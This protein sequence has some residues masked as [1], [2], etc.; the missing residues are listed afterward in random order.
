MKLLHTIQN[1]VE[2]KEQPFWVS[3][4]LN[5]DDWNDIKDTVKL[6]GDDLHLYYKAMDKLGLGEKF[7]SRISTW[8]ESPYWYITQALGGLKAYL[9]DDM[10]MG[11]LKKYVI[12]YIIQDEINDLK[13]DKDGKIYITLDMY[14][15]PLFFDD[16]SGN[17]L[18][19][20]ETAQLIFEGK[21]GEN[22]NDYDTWTPDLFELLENLS[23]PNY[24]RLVHNVL[25]NHQ[26]LTCFREEFETWVKEDGIGENTFYVDS[27]RMNS[28]LNDDDRYNFEVLLNCAEELEEYVSDLKN[29]YIRAFNGTLLQQYYEEYSKALED[30]LGK[31]VGKE[32]T[33]DY[34]GKEK[35]TLEGDVYEI[36][37]LVNKTLIRMAVDGDNIE[38]SNFA[39][40]YKDFYGGLCPGHFDYPDDDDKIWEEYNDLFEAYY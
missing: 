18:S 29:F 22:W 25:K 9:K 21:M 7:I 13:K 5:S 14:D 34:R 38:Y 2:Q 28:F 30:L 31:P 12:D 4:A 23:R 40:N 33:Y 32:D 36:T 17:M 11:L 6:F 39:E 15:K 27:Y 19:C 8:Y 35:I 16:D 3:Q 26:T 10:D 24:E 37:D 1:L 20:M